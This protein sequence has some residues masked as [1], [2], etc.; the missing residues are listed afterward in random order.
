[1]SLFLLFLCYEFLLGIEQNRVHC[2]GEFYIGNTQKLSDL[3]PLSVD[4]DVKVLICDPII[5]W[6]EWS[7]YASL[8]SIEVDLLSHF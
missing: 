6:L 3:H 5:N 7:C 4:V 1:M 2:K 8:N